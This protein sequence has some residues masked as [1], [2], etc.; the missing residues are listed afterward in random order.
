MDFVCLFEAGAIR[1]VRIIVVATDPTPGPHFGTYS[2]VPAFTPTHLYAPLILSHPLSCIVTPFF[3]SP[4]HPPSLFSP[5]FTLVHLCPPLSTFVQLTP[6]T[7]V[8]SH[9]PL[10]ISSTLI[11]H[12]PSP[13][14]H[15]PPSTLAPLTHSIHL[16]PLSTN[17]PHPYHPHLPP[18]AFALIPHTFQ[19]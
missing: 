5:S 19:A 6:S 18:E 10:S 17:T 14:S 12:Y 13:F 7:S 4:P 16:P 1:Y 9:L 11:F 15:R 2:H 8:R 3:F